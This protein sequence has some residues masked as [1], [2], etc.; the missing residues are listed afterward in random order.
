MHNPHALPFSLQAEAREC[1]L[2]RLTLSVQSFAMSATVQ[3]HKDKV[4]CDWSEPEQQWIVSHL[5]THERRALS[6]GSW[7]IAWDDDGFGYLVDTEA[8]GGDEE[9]DET[10]LEAWLRY[11]LAATDDGR[12]AVIETASPK[13]HEF[14]DSMS[15]QYREY[16]IGLK[17]GATQK[18]HT[19]ASAF[20][21]RH[22]V[23]FQIFLSLASLYTMLGFTMLGGVASRWAWQSLPAFQRRVSKIAPEQIMRSQAFERQRDQSQLAE[24]CL[25][26]HGASS[27][28][29][30]VLLA[31]WSCHSTKAGGLK[32]ERHRMACQ[33]MLVA[34][35][36]SALGHN[37]HR[38]PIFA[39]DQFAWR[40]PRPP[41]GGHMFWMTVQAS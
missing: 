26:W 32:E 19:F 7:A 14:V 38:V 4:H 23:G 6:D 29:V 12:L 40:W 35:A 8:E 31:S 39:D 11:Q 30:V 33:E 1:G 13:S 2:R 41:V 21:R 37:S 3:P 9:A 10:P 27:V 28:A 17:L 24:R 16:K 34:I 36:Q 5:D 25:P 18:V 22:R 15:L 20:F